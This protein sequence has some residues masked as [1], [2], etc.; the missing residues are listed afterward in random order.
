MERLQ[1][2]QMHLYQD[3]IV[4]SISYCNSNTSLR[5]KNIIIIREKGKKNKGILGQSGQR[6]IE[7]R[8]TAWLCAMQYST[9][10][11]EKKTNKEKRLPTFVTLT[12]SDVQNHSDSFIKR[13]MLPLFLDQLRY[14]HDLKHYFWRAEKEK[15][16]RIHFHC[17]LDC[18][19]Q[20]KILQNIWN[21]IL[22]KNGYIENYEKKTGKTQPPSTHIRAIKTISESVE[23]VMKY[24]Q[25][26]ESEQMID[27]ALYQF[28]R[29][30]ISLKPFSFQANP[31]YLPL[32]TAAVNEKSV[33][34]F[35]SQWFSI[36]DFPAGEIITKLDPEIILEH[37]KYY[38]QIFTNLYLPDIKTTEQKDMALQS[39]ADPL[40]GEIRPDP[41][42]SIRFPRF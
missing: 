20:K 24:C 31:R 12:L 16:Q 21:S 38:D 41:Q 30:L 10:N 5:K 35:H 40:T 15:N 25:K 11:Q 8:L 27:G 18:Y 29:A 37:Q 39:S 19:V 13:K 42:T 7:K 17:V 22:K 34:Q 23:Y 26:K 36:Y 6:K 14:N 28:S 2:E 4:S 32:T 9:W 1:I 3:R 33:Y